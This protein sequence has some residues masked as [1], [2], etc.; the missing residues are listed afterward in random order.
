MQQV[1]NRVGFGTL[2]FAAVV[3]MAAPVSGVAFACLKNKANSQDACGRAGVSTV[4]SCS[5]QILEN[6]D[7]KET[8]WDTYGQESAENYER[9]C[10]W[11][12]LKQNPD[13]GGCVNN[14]PEQSF[15]ADCSRASG[16]SCREWDPV[17]R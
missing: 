15:T 11:Q 12:P 13:G 9:L 5:N 16:S 8:V 1:V 2:V 10:R 7:C 4:G 3:A 17:P 14:G 6:G